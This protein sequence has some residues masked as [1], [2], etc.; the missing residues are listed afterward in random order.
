VRLD[1]TA[2]VIGSTSEAELAKNALTAKYPQY[3]RVAIPG[4]V[5]AFEIVAWVAWP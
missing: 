5:V 1:G 3:G 2:R 4:P